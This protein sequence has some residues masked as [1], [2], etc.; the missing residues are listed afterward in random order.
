MENNIYNGFNEPIPPTPEV[1]RI[2]RILQSK[3]PPPPAMDEF[4]SEAIMPEE[5]QYRPLDRFKEALSTGNRDA[6]NLD[7]KASMF[8]S[9]PRYKDAAIEWMAQ[10]PD[11]I[12]PNNSYQVNTKLAEFSKISGYS[13]RQPLSPQQVSIQ[14][15]GNIA[16]GKGTNYFG[17]KQADEKH[18]ADLAASEALSQ[19]RLS[20]GS[21]SATIQMYN[22]LKQKFPEMD[23]MTLIR[24]AQ[25]KV[26]T[27]LEIDP[28]TGR[29]RDIAGAATGLGNLEYGK[30]FG[31]ASGTN[32]A[33][34]TG[35]PLIESAVVS[36][37]NIADLLSKQ[38]LSDDQAMPLLDGLDS[39]NESTFDTPYAN[40][41]QVPAQFLDKYKDQTVAFD[42]MEQS[43]TNLAIPLAKALGVNPTDKDFNATLD[44][45]FN[46]KSS[47]ASRRAQIAA[48]RRRIAARRA[49]NPIQSGVGTSAG[50]GAGSDPLGIR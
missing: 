1:D 12:D 14:D 23:E 17:L 33:D 10:H 16:S 7:K 22:L 3:A 25:N 41:A 35:K 24:M 27:N 32:A 19:N 5:A 43:R 50:A 38:G 42:L 9:D 48:L 47:K 44:S 49:N 28:N 20:G 21:D 6:V 15:L 18:L 34:L 2:T 40:V 29:A 11:Q 39:L 37:R 36:A 45:I 31:G 30:D 8:F 13:N 4:A 46:V 26:G